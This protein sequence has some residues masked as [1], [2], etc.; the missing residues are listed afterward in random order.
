MSDRPEEHCW[1]CDALTGKAG[2]GE[3][4]IFWLDGQLGPLCDECNDRLRDEVFDNAGLSAEVTN[5]ITRLRAR[6]ANRDATIGWLTAKVEGLKSL[7]RAERNQ[8]FVCCGKLNSVREAFNAIT[9]KKLH[10]AAQAAKGKP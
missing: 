4:S 7:Y 9:E 8:R 5:H 10:E 2:A 3:D 6:I 1:N